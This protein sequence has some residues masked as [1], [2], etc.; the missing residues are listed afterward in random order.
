[1][2]RTSIIWACYWQSV[3][4]VPGAQT[5]KPPDVGKFGLSP[6]SQTPSLAYVHVSSQVI[7]M[8]L[9]SQYNLFRRAKVPSIIIVGRGDVFTIPIIG[10]RTA[11]SHVLLDPPLHALNIGVTTP[12]A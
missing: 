6:S 10:E 11:S 12:D 8:T 3:Q 2:Q 9:D 4:S 1:M 5:S 7:L